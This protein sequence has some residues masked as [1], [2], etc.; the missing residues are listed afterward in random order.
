MSGEQGTYQ[1]KKC[2][3]VAKMINNQDD[4]IAVFSVCVKHIRH[5]SIH[6]HTQLVFLGDVI[7]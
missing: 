7:G 5:P 4:F 3:S 6:R 1:N 2:L